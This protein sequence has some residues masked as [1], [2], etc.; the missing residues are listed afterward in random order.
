MPAKRKS[1]DFRLNAKIQFYTWPQCPLVKQH[2]HDFI[3]AKGWPIVN[4]VVCEE[5][6]EGGDPHMHAW[7]SYGKRV[8]IRSAASLYLKS[9][10]GT[11]YKGDFKRGDK[12]GAGYALKG[13]NYITNFSD[14]EVIRLKAVYEQHLADQEY[15][16]ATYGDVIKLAE[17]GKQAEAFKTLKHVDGRNMVLKGPAILRDNLQQLSQVK[18]KNTF[19]DFKFELSDTVK[20]WDRTKYAL[21]MIGPAKTGKTSFAMSLFKHPLKLNRLDILKQ[22][23]P[24]VYDGLVFDDMSFLMHSRD[25]VV[26]VT[27]VE[28]DGNINVKF[29]TATIPAGTPRVFTNNTLPFNLDPQGAIR[30]RIH[31]VFV[32]QD[33][34]VMTDEQRIADIKP[35]DDLDELLGETVAPEYVRRGDFV[36]PAD[37]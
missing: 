3:V 1:G 33:M 6:H 14:E 26:A 5:K 16:D 25:T 21:V 17:K 10:D 2:A 22:F 24:E 31:V 27:T 34:R 29:A 9:E 28:M 36:Y 15:A 4:Y 11:V 7:Y 37:E 30:R 23:D 19:A 12:N 20:R 32:Q 35:D 13:N 8:D 18:V